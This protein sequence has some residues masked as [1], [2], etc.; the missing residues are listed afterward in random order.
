MLMKIKLRYILI[1]VFFGVILAV[2]ISNY[3]YS[4]KIIQEKYDL[5]KT[6]IEKALTEELIFINTSTKIL[7]TQLNDEMKNISYELIDKYIKNPQIMSWD[8]ES[9]K[10]KFQNYEI[11]II[12]EGLQ[13]IRSTFK[14]DLGL[15]FSKYPAFSRLLR[16]RLEGDEFSADRMDISITTKALRKYS[17]MPTP[18]N[19]YLLELS[20]DISKRYPDFQKMDILS[21]VNTL[22]EEY[23]IVEN[24]SIYK[25]NEDG[26]RIGIIKTEEL[27]DG[28]DTNIS[29]DKQEIIREALN[30][31][32]KKTTE[33]VAQ[34][35][36]NYIFTYIPI[37]NYLD[38]Q[39]FDWWNSYI[40]EMIYNDIPLNH[41]L[42]ELRNRFISNLV[43]LSFIFILFSLVI[44]RL[45]N[46]TENMAYYDHL[47]GLPNRKL[48]EKVFME[49]INNADKNGNLLG[50]MFMDLDH[51]K[52][53]NDKYGHEIGDD[54]LIAVSQKIKNNLKKDDFV[55]RLGGDEFTI[56][57]DNIEKKKDLEY[58]SKRLIT[59]FDE[60][61]SIHKNKIKA[62]L[63]IGVSVYPDSGDNI[64]DLL[65][66]SDQAMY[67][68]KNS[69]TSYRL[70]IE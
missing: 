19:K 36:R 8:L 60:P 28:L 68:A 67:A 31:N 64:K 9:I 35:K 18:D 33:I 25:F 40:I 17:Y 55:A 37:L 59:L 13:I 34:N 22:K 50:V 32:T 26:S 44:F 21:K 27:E 61:L 46:K 14:E 2:T 70:D 10:E 6:H 16:S 3:T 1:I 53:V 20:I 7:E 48:F 5:Q 47:T 45:F 52:D 4:R 56:I 23:D 29:V 63:S 62:N 57:L 66:K 12:N 30:E 41:Q 11:Y 65:R 38:N 43:I 69:K 54:L 42:S 24:I 49:K 51:F 15:D 39:E 58:I